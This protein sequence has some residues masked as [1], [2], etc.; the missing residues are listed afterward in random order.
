MS[1]SIN[2]MVV[3]LDKMRRAIGSGDRKLIEAIQKDQEWFLSTI[4]DIDDEAELKCAQ[5]VEHLIV[6]N[7]SDDYPGYLY[8]YALEAICRQLGREL[9]NICPICGAGDWLEEVDA[10]LKIHKIPLEIS[11]LVFGLCPVEIPQPDDYPMIGSWPPQSIPPALAA[12]KWLE[13]FG[14]DR[15]MTDTFRQIRSWLADAATT[16]ECAIVG[17]LS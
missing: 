3:E 7:P 1:N 10:A 11:T 12:L 17:F 15:E 9:E 16:P 5:A 13:M 8:G 14:M 4:D 6:G 2:V